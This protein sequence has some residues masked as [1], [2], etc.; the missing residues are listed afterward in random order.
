MP[1]CSCR[2]GPSSLADSAGEGR[3]RGGE[4]W[5]LLLPV[6]GAGAGSS[7][8]SKAALAHPSRVRPALC[9]GEVGAGAHMKLVVNMVRP[10]SKDGAAAALEQLA[11]ALFPASLSPCQL[12]SFTKCC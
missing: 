11:K 1:W 9:A 5:L 6:V 3:C 12:P 7:R 8:S 4:V 2:G 10:G